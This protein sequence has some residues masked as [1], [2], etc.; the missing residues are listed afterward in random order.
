MAMKPVEWSEEN[1][2]DQYARIKAGKVIEFP[3]PFDQITQIDLDLGRVKK[4]AACTVIPESCPITQDCTPELKVIRGVP[5]WTHCVTQKSLE[6]Y[7]ETQYVGSARSLQTVGALNAK[8]LDSY[9]VSALISKL[10]AVGTKILN[11]FA[12]EREYDSIETLVSYRDD[13]HEKFAREAD[14]G[15]RARSQIWQALNNLRDQINAGATNLPT[16]AEEVI[17][18]FPTLSWE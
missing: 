6:N 12:K 9:E 14:Q 15:I 4:V 3:V 18:L 5:T 11:D 1:R 16:T 2:H 8:V 13:P 17:N 10:E 7:I